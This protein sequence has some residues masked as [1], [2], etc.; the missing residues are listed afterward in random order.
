MNTAVN[1]YVTIT[2]RNIQCSDQQQIVGL[3]VKYGI[4]TSNKPKLGRYIL[5]SGLC[6]IINLVIPYSV[7]TSNKS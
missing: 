1:L 2:Y 5:R 3:V 7:L 4:L 6:Q